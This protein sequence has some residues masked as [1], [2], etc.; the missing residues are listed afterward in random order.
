MT[1][2][3]VATATFAALLL[4]I[5]PLAPARAERLLTVVAGNSTIVPSPGLK[6]VAVGNSTVVGVVPAGNQLVINGKAP[7]KS[8]VSLWMTKGRIDYAVVVTESTLDTVTQVLR[9]AIDEP[10]VVVSETGNA[11][12]ITGRVSTVNEGQRLADIVSRFQSFAHDGHFTIINSVMVGNPLGDLRKSLANDSATAGANIESDGKGNLVVS[13]SVHDRTD[14]EKVLERVRSSAGAYLAADGKIIDRLTTETT[15]QIA[16]KVSI[17]EV[18]KTGLRQLG[19]RLQ[20][21]TPNPNQP[22]TYTIGAPSFVGIE[23]PSVQNPGRALTIAPFF[24]LTQLAPTL[25][26]IINEG[27]ARI[28]SSPDLVTTPGRE[29][30]FLV[31]GEIPYAYSTGLG[32]VSIVFKEYGVKLRITPVLLG[33]GTVETKIEPEVSDLD[34]TDGIQLN[35]F[36]VPALKTSRL[37]TDVITHA[38]DSVIM[39]GLLRRIEMRNINKIPLLGDLPILGKLFRSTQYQQNDSDVVFVMTP[40]VIVR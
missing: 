23:G 40:D 20:G 10:G 24:R 18:D 1:A 31:G 26:L 36:V 21:A 7:G 28:L 8:T 4:I 17:L 25:D 6:R 33:N 37:S 11:I 19:I 27:H 22:G 16:I 2:L 38:G 13:G 39:G 9:Q 3:R 30:S 35:G 15:T 32:Q 5:A 14:A 29:A 34:F 12:L